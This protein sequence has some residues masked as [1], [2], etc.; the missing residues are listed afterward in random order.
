MTV[1]PRDVIWDEA[2]ALL[3]HVS[4]AETLITALL[5]R[6]VWLASNDKSKTGYIMIPTDDPRRKYLPPNPIPPLPKRPK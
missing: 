5:V 4:Y 2:Q 3:Y 1:D 6:W